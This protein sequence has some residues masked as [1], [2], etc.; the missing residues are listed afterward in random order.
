MALLRE[1]PPFAMKSF[2][3]P[4]CILRRMTFELIEFVTLP[5]FLIWKGI[6]FHSFF[7]SV[8]RSAPFFHG[9]II[10]AQTMTRPE[11]GVIQIKR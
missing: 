4:P 2:F 5:E 9:Y 1:G 3:S 10:A 6:L 7:S 11:N 8:W